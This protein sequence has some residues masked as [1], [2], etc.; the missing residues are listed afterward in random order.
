MNPRLLFTVGSQFLEN[1]ESVALKGSIEFE[2]HSRS[3]SGSF[4]MVMNRGDSLAF[5]IEGPLKIDV[6]RLILVDNIAYYTDRETGVWSEIPGNEKL[7]LPDYGIECIR[8]DALVYYVFPQFY[9]QKGQGLNLDKM[10]ISSDD[11]DFYLTPSGNNSSFTLFNQ[12]LNL[13][14]SYSRRKDLGNGY[15]PSHVEI[16]APY[17]NWRISLEIEKIKLNPEKSAKIWDRD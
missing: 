8:P 10:I 12:G 2:D 4:Q 6:F 5:I 13:T 17:E 16:Y 1:V 15:Y 11:Y 7:I 14:A 9:F 3:Q